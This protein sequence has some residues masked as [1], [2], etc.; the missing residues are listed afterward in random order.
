MSTTAATSFLEFG[1]FHLDPVRCRLLKH[2]VPVPLR[3]KAF[4]LLLALAQRCGEDVEK[5]ELINLVWPDAIVEENNLPHTISKLRKALDERLDEH[6]YIVT[7][8]GRGYRFVAPIRVIS[9]AG[10]NPTAV[11]P[12]G[13][14]APQGRQ[15]TRLIVLPFRLLRPDP[16]V[17][18]LT[19]SLPDAVTG[20]LSGLESLDV[21][22]S[23]TAAQ[24]TGDTPDPHVIA[25]RAKV[26][27]VLTGTLLRAGDQLRLNTQLVEAQSRT[28][29]WS[30]TSQVSLGNILH[31][32][33]DLVRRIVASLSPQLTARDRRLLK[34]D[35]STRTV[36]PQVYASCLKGRYHW[37]RR[38]PEGLRRAIAC[39]DAAIERDPSYGPAH[40]G[41]ADCYML[42][43]TG[44]LSRRETMAR[45]KAAATKALALDDELAEAHA[46][47]AAV[48]FRWDWDWVTAEREFRRAIQLNPGAASVR[49]GYALF[50]TAMGRFPEGLA[51]MTH[52]CEIDPLS[53]VVGAGLGRILDF[54]RRHDEAIE[55]YQK[56]LDIDSGFA[57]AHFD[58]ANSHL[59][60]G[61]YEEA[62]AAARRAVAIAPDSLVYAET[63]AFTRARMG[64]RADAEELLRLMNLQS[65]T[66]YVS[67]ALRAHLLLGLERIDEALAWLHVGC[68]ERAAEIIYLNVDPDCDVVR[69]DPRFEQ[70][71]RRIAFPS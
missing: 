8:P 5:D 53:L 46:S 26:D 6:R 2:G 50:L 16:E 58:L 29:L 28:V 39:F 17:E 62:L 24:F 35:V 40:A 33:D 51:E 1:P 34:R 41:L 15:V 13:P 65:E 45:A 36:D 69:S 60:S 71:L 11:A 23:A 44:S 22:S 3:P 47:L 54:A 70:L 52:A 56:T 63:V 57:D 68:D 4:Q 18:F 12:G 20:L 14:T 66:G 48:A 67:P 49:H 25:E 43:G 59:Y 38:T 31:V 55:Q 27:V 30:Q 9:G 37:N 7:V 19:F 64:C 61:R 10:E 21:R 42:G 32:Q